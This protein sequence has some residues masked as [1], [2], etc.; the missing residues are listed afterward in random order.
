[1]RKELRT[2]LLL[3]ILF[4]CFFTFFRVPHSRS[5]GTGFDNAEVITNGTHY[6]ISFPVDSLNAYFKI[7][8][9]INDSL[10]VTLSDFGHPTFDLDLYLYNRYKELVNSSAGVTAS[11]SC[12][13]TAGI[14]GYFY[15]R[16]EKEN[17]CGGSTGETQ[18]N[19]TI[20]GATG[21]PQIPSFKF[22][23]IFLGLFMVISI[24]I[25]FRKT[26]AES[27]LP[28]SKK[29]FSILFQIAQKEF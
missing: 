13:G 8:C 26:S 11:E 18:F 9:S 29:I 12:N 19:L 22:V 5:Y 16:I 7:Y 10:Q 14:N 1:M 23:Q 17:C 28:S 2:Y 27:T 25:L 20:F 4:C 6:N 3:I 15:I 24:F 21:S